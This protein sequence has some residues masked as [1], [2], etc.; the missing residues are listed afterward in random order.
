VSGED[1]AVI[2][3]D[4]GMMDD[5]LPNNVLAALKR[6]QSEVRKKAALGEREKRGTTV[7][8]GDDVICMEVKGQ[9]AEPKVER[10]DVEQGHLSLTVEVDVH[11]DENHNNI[12]TVI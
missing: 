4:R 11:D 9:S 2:I 5:H 1:L 10:S 12:T 8:R 6:C 3:V 7:D